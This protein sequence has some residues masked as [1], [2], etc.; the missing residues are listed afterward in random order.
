MK[1]RRL[2]S[3][4]HAMRLLWCLFGSYI[5]VIIDNYFRIH[6]RP[7]KIL[8]TSN[9]SIW[10]NDFWCKSMYILKVHSIH[11]TLDNTQI[12]EKF[13]SDKI[14]GTKNVLFFFCELQLI[15]VLL[16]ICDYHM[17]WNT[18]FVSLKLC[19]HFPFLIPFRFY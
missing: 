15:T 9:K 13:P 4:V 16:L 6:W 19:W 8:E 3:L 1:V 5:F 12:F 10:S 18:W 7:S 14:N 17:S 2:L 11:C